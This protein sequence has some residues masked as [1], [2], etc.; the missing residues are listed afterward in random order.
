MLTLLGFVVALTVFYSRPELHRVLDPVE[1]A[2]ARATE[3]LVAATGLEVERRGTV[4]RHPEGFACEIYH[5]CTGIPV[6]ALLA[7]GLWALPGS[8]RSRIA[9]AALGTA[10]ILAVN[11]A[12]LVHVY[13]LGV[14]RPEAFAAAHGIYWETAMVLLVVAFWAVWTRTSGRS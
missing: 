9:G 4:L 6:A 13:S 11:L 14:R 12:R 1:R 2:T 7:A 5:R 10:L 3:A 8:R